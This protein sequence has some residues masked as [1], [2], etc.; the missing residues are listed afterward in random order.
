MGVEAGGSCLRRN[1]ERGAQFLPCGCDGKGRGN[2]GGE[3]AWRVGQC[4]ERV[5]VVARGVLPPT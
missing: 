5:A 4:R 2:D 1:D 3:V